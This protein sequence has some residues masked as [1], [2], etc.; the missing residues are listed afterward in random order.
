MERNNTLHK[1]N[2]IKYVLFL[3]SSIFQPFHKHQIWEYY[4]EE[5]NTCVPLVSLTVFG[6]RKATGN[7][8]RKIIPSFTIP[9]IYGKVD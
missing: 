1:H 7:A 6:F 2:F 8:E 5:Q 9:G 3:Y 4:R